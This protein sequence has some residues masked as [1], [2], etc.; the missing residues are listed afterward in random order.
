MVRDTSDT[1]SIYR[2]RIDSANKKKH[3]LGGATETNRVRRGAAAMKPPARG[4]QL[5]PR[6]PS[7]IRATR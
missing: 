5:M 6:L 4:G 2:L 1:K 3:K 7:L